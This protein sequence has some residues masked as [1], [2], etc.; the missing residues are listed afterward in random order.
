MKFV[1]YRNVSLHNRGSVFRIIL[2][3]FELP[4]YNLE[5]GGN[6]DLGR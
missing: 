3:H 5:L 1:L 4:D 6:V 2:K